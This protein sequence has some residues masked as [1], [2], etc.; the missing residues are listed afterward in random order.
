[1]YQWDVLQS[2]VRIGHCILCS[3]S[4]QPTSPVWTARQWVYSSPR[5]DTCFCGCCNAN[6]YKIRLQTYLSQIAL[7]HRCEPSARLLQE[8]VGSLPLVIT[9]CVRSA[10]GQSTSAGT[11]KRCS[12][13][14]M[15]T[16]RSAVCLI[17]S[18]FLSLS[19]I[20]IH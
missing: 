8:K 4:L 10:V 18:A 11:Q 20:K 19:F 15:P 17:P 7:C 3:I 14:H 12:V 5:E 9:R 6:G 16:G 2:G 13:C 1:M